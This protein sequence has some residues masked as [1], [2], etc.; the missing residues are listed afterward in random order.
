MG[1]IKGITKKRCDAVPRGGERTICRKKKSVFLRIRERN[2]GK[3][4]QGLKER[5]VERG[6]VA[7][8]NKI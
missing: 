4:G 2:H 1:R 8:L 6:V 3:K 5:V 7:R